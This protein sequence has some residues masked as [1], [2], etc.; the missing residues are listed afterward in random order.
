MN[1]IAV[2]EDVMG[3]LPVGVLVGRPELRHPACCRIRQG[4]RQVDRRGSS[5]D[6]GLEGLQDRVGLIAQKSLGQHGML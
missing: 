4:A 6:G 3:R 2:A 1:G 5:P